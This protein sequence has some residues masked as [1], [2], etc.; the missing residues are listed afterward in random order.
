MAPSLGSAFSVI[1][2]RRKWIPRMKENVLKYRPLSQL[3]S[4][5]SLYLGV[6]DF[7]ADENCTKQRMSEEGRL[8]I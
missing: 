2:G 3:A 7:H 8:A 1:V 5:R 6:L 4:F